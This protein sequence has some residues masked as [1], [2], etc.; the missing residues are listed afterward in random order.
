VPNSV[1]CGLVATMRGFRMVEQ[2]LR[3]L[4][5][6]HRYLPPPDSTGSTL[7]NRMKEEVVLTFVR[8]R[9]TRVRDF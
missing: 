8:P 4:P 5:T 6:M 7:A 9:L 2:S 1:I 3:P